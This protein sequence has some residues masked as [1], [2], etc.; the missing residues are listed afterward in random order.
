M[1]WLDGPTGSISSIPCACDDADDR[2]EG[3]CSSLRLVALG[4]TNS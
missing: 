3:E 4:I 1:S 2:D